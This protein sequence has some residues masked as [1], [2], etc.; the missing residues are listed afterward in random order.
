MTRKETWTTAYASALADPADTLAFLPQPQSFRDRTIRQAVRLR[1][2]GS[3]LR[4]VLSN[5]Y[6]QT[7]LVIDTVAVSSGQGKPPQTATFHG[8]ARW[9]IPPG[10][11]AASDAVRLPVAAGEEIS[12]SCYVAGTAGPAAFLHSAQRT[13]HAAT[14]NQAAQDQLAGPGDPQSFPS[15]YWIT[16]VLTDAPADGPVSVTSATPTTCR[17][18]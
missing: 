7:P 3:R 17:P 5:E 16:R 14:G 4:L 13:G 9:E 11:T 12:V 8:S 2:G 15:L 10:Q 18:G 6:G 1:R